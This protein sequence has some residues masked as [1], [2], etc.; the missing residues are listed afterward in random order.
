[1]TSVVSGTRY[2]R[3]G[4]TGCVKII[5]KESAIAYFKELSERTLNIPAVHLEKQFQTYRNDRSVYI[6]RNNNLRK[7]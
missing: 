7:Q 6:V 2:M 1:M 4:D 3:R 5:T